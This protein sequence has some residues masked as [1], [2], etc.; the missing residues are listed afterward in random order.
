MG[1]RY[2]PLGNQRIPLSPS[3]RLRSR[4]RP[5]PTL[6]VITADRSRTTEI[7]GSTMIA[8]SCS[9]RRGAAACLRSPA[10]GRLLYRR[11]RTRGTTLKSP[12]GQS[13]YFCRR[14]ATS[15][16]PGR[17]YSALRKGQSGPSRIHTLSR[18]SSG[19]AFG[20]SAA[21]ETEDDPFS[22]CRRSEA[23]ASKC[24]FW[25]YSDS[26]W[27]MMARACD[28][29]PKL[30]ICGVARNGGRSTPWI[31][32]WDREYFIASASNERPGVLVA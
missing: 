24:S 12:K 28:I 8:A 17:L 25:P 13:R 10:G 4:R 27:G 14:P 1:P 18:S 32:L 23:H 19:Q 3:I 26:S 9:S 21:M 11:K 20:P 29:T 2:L 5:S 31:D 22:F 16:L 6:T 7:A 30:T 15:G